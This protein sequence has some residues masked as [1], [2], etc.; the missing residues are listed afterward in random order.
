MPCVQITCG[1]WPHGVTKEMDGPHTPHPDRLQM[2]ED[3]LTSKTYRAVRGDR[4]VSVAQFQW[5]A[6]V[7]PAMKQVMRSNY[8]RLADRM[9]NHLRNSSISR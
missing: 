1:F 6:N 5:P 3:V 8:C 7:S 4:M 9:T 2:I